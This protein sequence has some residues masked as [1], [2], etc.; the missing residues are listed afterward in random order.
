MGS[1]DEERYLDPNPIHKLLINNFLK[2]I[3]DTV[4]SLNCR[5]ILDVGCG[6]GFVT[7][8]ISRKGRNIIGID[9]CKEK[10]EKAKKRVKNAK[11]YVGDVYHLP[12]KPNFFDLVIATEMLEHLEDPNHALS[13]I[14]VVTSKYFLTSVPNEPL[15]TFTNLIR[16]R[17]LNRWGSHKEHIHKWNTSSFTKMVSEYFKIIEVKKPFPHIVVLCEKLE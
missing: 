11:F 1:G 2:V 16:L 15:Y 9:I 14:K 6:E 10:I 13:N 3:A 5:K 8:K 7:E 17:Y 4:D 12:F